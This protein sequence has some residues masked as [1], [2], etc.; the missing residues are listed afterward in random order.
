[1]TVQGELKETNILI[2]GVEG[3]T[4]NET[5]QWKIHCRWSWT[6]LKNEGGDQVWVNR[7][8]FPTWG[9]D[10]RGKVPVQVQARGCKKQSK[11]KQEETGQEYY[12][13]SIDWMWQ[14]DVIQIL[15]HEPTPL[16]TPTFSTNGGGSG[17]G[18]LD[19]RIAWNSSINNSVHLHGPCAPG[20]APGFAWI[21][22]NAKE[23]Y[24]MIVAGPPQ[25]EA[26]PAYPDATEMGSGGPE[27]AVEGVSPPEPQGTTAP[28]PTPLQRVSAKSSPGK[29][30]ELK[31]TMKAMGCERDDVIKYCCDNF[32]ERGPDDLVDAEV[33]RLT[34]AVL[35][36]QI[37]GAW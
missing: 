15:D 6:P 16:P 21:H 20:Q 24:N 13:G 12:D 22:T 25:E 37:T 10:T 30:N 31:E 27:M 11:A 4:W 29:L 9:P 35:A 23:I 36:G 17:R 19:Q 7:A 5:P 26:E 2:T 34:E 14:W 1:M 3:A 8:S 28:A 18:D 33:D 32:D